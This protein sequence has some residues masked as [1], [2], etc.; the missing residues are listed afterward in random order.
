MHALCLSIT[1]HCALASFSAFIPVQDSVAVWFHFGLWTNAFESLEWVIIAF[2]KS[3]LKGLFIVWSHFYS[4]WWA[5]IYAKLPPLLY[6][7]WSCREWTCGPGFCFWVNGPG[8]PK[9]SWSQLR[10]WLGAASFAWEERRVVVILKIKHCSFLLGYFQEAACWYVVALV[11][12]E[13]K[14]LDLGVFPFLL[15]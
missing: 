10:L 5:S 2:L 4:K 7:G 13:L 6:C 12:L 14:K 8:F 9:P 15:A 11:E 3:S 1:P